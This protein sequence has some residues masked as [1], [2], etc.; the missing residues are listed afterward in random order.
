[1]KW[2]TG[3]PDSRK[4]YIVVVHESDEKFLTYNNVR[5]IEMELTWHTMLCPTRAPH[6][7]DRAWTQAP[8]HLLPSPF[9]FAHPPILHTVYENGGVV[10]QRGSHGGRYE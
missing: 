5:L 1:M 8:F 10:S 3:H 6:A 9:P 4:V 2:T 7:S